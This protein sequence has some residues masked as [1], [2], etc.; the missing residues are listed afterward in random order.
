MGRFFDAVSSIC[1]IRNAVTY[2][3]QASIELENSIVSGI[4]DSYR[5]DIKESS[6]PYEINPSETIKEIIADRFN[7]KP[8]GIISAKFHNT[9]INFTSDLCIKIRNK[10]SINSVALSG[11]VFQNSYL[12]KSTIERLK[13]KVLKYMHIKISLQ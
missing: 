13:K 7:N 2:E 6:L 8:A 5:Y 3:G 4:S 9:V 10:T 1:G 12:L 11:G